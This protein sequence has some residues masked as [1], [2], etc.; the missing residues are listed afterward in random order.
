[1]L[2]SHQPRPSILQRYMTKAPPSSPPFLSF[3]SVLNSVFVA[4][5]SSPFIKN[6][7]TR[8]KAKKPGPKKAEPLATTF[9]CLFCNHEKSV[10]VKL[11]KKAGVG[12]LSCKVCGQSFQ[13]SVNYL[14]APVDVYSDWV[15]ACDSLSK[16]NPDT[17]RGNLHSLDG[18]FSGGGNRNGRGLDDE[19]DVDGYEGEGI[20]PDDEF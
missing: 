2:V 20:V 9:G 15:D 12:Q 5:S 19:N 11:D 16:A 8:K 13:C 17:S 7:Q 4:Y 3:L 6:G 18:G 10:T 1:L 14:S